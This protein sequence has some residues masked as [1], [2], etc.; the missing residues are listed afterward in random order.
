MLDPYWPIVCHR[1]RAPHLHSGPEKYIYLIPWTLEL[2]ML[3]KGEQHDRAVNNE[4]VWK[5]RLTSSLLNNLGSPISSLFRMGAEIIET[6]AEVF[7]YLETSQIAIEWMKL[8]VTAK[9]VRY[10]HE[11]F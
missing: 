8:V 1:Q 11:I 4:L 2:W 3:F 5:N 6:T 10:S 9:D 7:S